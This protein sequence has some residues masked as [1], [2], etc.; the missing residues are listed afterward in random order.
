MHRANTHS[1]ILSAFNALKGITLLWY[2]KVTVT[3]S[4]SK[5]THI[6]ASYADTIADV[7]L[8]YV[9]RI[10]FTAALFCQ[11]LPPSVPLTPRQT[12]NKTQLPN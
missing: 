1:D 6:G 9:F 3:S 5:M 12:S 11:Y 10:A 4:D 7:V 8:L 2:L